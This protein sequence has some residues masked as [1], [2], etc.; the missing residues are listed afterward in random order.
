MRAPRDTW[1]TR[2]G[3]WVESTAI[4]RFV[5]IVI[6]VNAV[7]L[8]LE[9]SPPVMDAAGGLLIGI[10]TLCL[11]IFVVEIVLKLTAF[12][13]SFFRSAWNV[14]DFIVVSVALVPAG[15]GFAVLRALRVL[16]VLRL[17]STMPQL[18]KVVGALIAAIPGVLSTGALL[19]LI[20][21]V[22]AVMATTFFA[23]TQPEYFGNLGITLFTLFQITTLS[24][25]EIIVRSTMEDHPWALAFFLP[26]ILISA[27]TALNLLIAVIVDA[28]N[29]LHDMPSTLAAS[30]AE[31]HDEADAAAP[32][33]PAASAGPTQPDGTAGAADT[34]GLERTA[35]PEGATESTDSRWLREEIQ[36]LRAEVSEL[37]TA[38]KQ[39]H[40]GGSN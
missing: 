26:Y 16:R 10:D 2:L 25:W 12:G 11:T 20:L 31:S 27:F 21:Y 35:G 6:I 39:R 19:M 30:S 24:S 32:A 3:E 37:T 8:G 5:I 9:T 14:F 7:V 13:W 33:D 29:T 40:P 28:M 23:E 38:L 34:A 1:R 15:E 22:S 36:A 17:V 4:Q 18:R